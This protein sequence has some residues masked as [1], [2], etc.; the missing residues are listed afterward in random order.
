MDALSEA[1]KAVR[2]TGAI[3]FH[4]ECRAPW[5]FTVPPMQEVM[6][7][8]AP[9]A[10]RVLGYNLVTEG[11]AV[12][13][14]GDGTEVPIRAGDIAIVP[15]GDPHTVTNGAPSEMIDSG[16]AL[17]EILRGGLTTMRF[18][19]GGEVTRFVCGYFG[20]E[21]HAD[22][23]F[24]AGL[25][26]LV[27]VN[28]R[29]DAAGEWL[30]GSIRHLVSEAGSGRPGRTVLLAKMAE[31]LFIEALRR[32]MEHLPPEQTGWL[33]GARDQI[34]GGALDA[35]HRKPS[36][37]WTMPNLAREVGTS[38][39]VLAE[40]FAHFLGEPPMTYLS[41]WR[42]QLA[43]RLLETT[44][45]PVVDVATEVG[46]ESE[47]AFNRAFKREFGEPPAR[48][49]RMLANGEAPQAGRHRPP[50]RSTPADREVGEPAVSAPALGSRRRDPDQDGPDGREEVGQRPADNSIG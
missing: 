7:I 18:G 32:Y 35:L 38:R 27:K 6:H 10:Q 36:H 46:Y 13:R 49:R 28:I 26:T 1:L 43:A 30:E 4:A 41:R 14:F 17:G 24:L 31:A 3:F 22:R 16:A 23:L 5:G 40:R 50:D 19:G 37:P 45:Q 44:R 12:V 42:L 34:V 21:R 33:A 11:R 15:H 8:L 47:A 9:G 39:S 48:Y 2:M 20:C 29:H 25:P